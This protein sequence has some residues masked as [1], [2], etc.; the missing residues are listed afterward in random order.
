MSFPENIHTKFPNIRNSRQFSD[1]PD[2]SRHYL[3]SRQFYQ[4]YQPC[5]EVKNFETTSVCCLSTK[6]NVILGISLLAKSCNTVDSK[7]DYDLPSEGL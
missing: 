4:M 5:L 6:K 2:F 1:F 3:I 7:S